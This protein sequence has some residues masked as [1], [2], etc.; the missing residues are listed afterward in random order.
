MAEEKKT[1]IKVEELADAQ[2]EQ[3][4]GGADS[5]ASAHICPICGGVEEWAQGP[6][7]YYCRN[8]MPSAFTGRD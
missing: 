5:S 2:L 3:V 6:M 7:D 8:C 1:P 4:A